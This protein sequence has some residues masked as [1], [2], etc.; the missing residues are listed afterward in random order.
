MS[1]VTM[2]ETGTRVPKISVTDTEAWMH[3]DQMDGF[4]LACGEIAEGACEPDA[5][6][7]TCNY[8]EAKKVYGFAELVLVGKVNITN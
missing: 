7:Y 8:C 1:T 5:R 4:C 2:N 3:D 6:E